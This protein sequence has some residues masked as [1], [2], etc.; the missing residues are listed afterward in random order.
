MKRIRVVCPSFD[1]LQGW[2]HAACRWPE[3]ETAAQLAIFR[4]AD[5]G[6]CGE[7]ALPEMRSFGV[8]FIDLLGQVDWSGGASAFARAVLTNKGN[9]KVTLLWTRTALI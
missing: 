2:N 7:S 4:G 5:L 9:E 8:N 3:V 6:Q 1:G